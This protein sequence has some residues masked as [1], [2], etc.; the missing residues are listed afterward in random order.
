MV[1]FV[2]ISARKSYRMNERPNYRAPGKGAL[3]TFGELQQARY[4][5]N[6]PLIR[7]ARFRQSEYFDPNYKLKIDF[8]NKL[9]KK[10]FIAGRNGDVESIR[11][12]FGDAKY[13]IFTKTGGALSTVA[14]V[15]ERDKEKK[16]EKEGGG[17]TKEEEGEENDDV[18]DVTASSPS[19]FPSPFPSPT[20][21]LEGVRDSAEAIAAVDEDEEEEESKAEERPSVSASP[22]TVPGTSTDTAAS[23]AA[24]RDRIMSGGGRGRGRGGRR[25]RSGSGLLGRGGSTSEDSFRHSSPYSTPQRP[26]NPQ[27]TKSR[28]RLRSLRPRGLAA[29]DGE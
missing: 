8:N 4:A 1:N 20:G 26:E 9:S 24:T 3:N 13:P 12:I 17:E 15:V 2:D 25:G 19:P 10:Q 27:S 21:P 11:K 29:G 16:K 23:V 18:V 5:S 6:A 7:N 14:G 22:G 28:E